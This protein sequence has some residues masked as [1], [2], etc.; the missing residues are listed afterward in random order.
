MTKSTKRKILAGA[1]RG[2][3]SV[4]AASVPVWMIA[5]K[6]PLWATTQSTATS[7]TGAGIVAAIIAALA[8][9]RKLFALIKAAA[10]KTKNMRAVTI[11]TVL[12]CGV[13]LWICHLVTRVQPIL[14]DIETICM[15]GVVS[16]LG[17][18]G[19]EWAS[20]AVSPK[21]KQETKEEA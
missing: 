11:G 17:G 9:R 21:K 6:F 13:G 16:G 4:V 5:Q 20:L 14:P 8:F 19:L 2:S 10:Q 12:I 15:G 18:V 7:L 1:L 3:S